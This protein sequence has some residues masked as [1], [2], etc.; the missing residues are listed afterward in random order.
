ML[1]PLKQSE[2]DKYA[3]YAYM[4]SQDLTKSCF[5]TYTDGIKTKEDFIKT[6][7]EAFSTN[8]SEILLF[9]HCGKTIGWI[10][11]YVLTPDKYISFHAFN[12]ESETEKAIDEFIEYI[13]PKYSGFTIYF[14]IPADNLKAASHLIELEF[15]MLEESNVDIL[16]FKDY[17]TRSEAQ[18]CIGVGKNNF[19]DF[20]KL[21][22]IY[23]SE[24]Y[25]NTA[26]IFEHLNE[27]NIFMLYENNEAAGAIYYYI[28]E[29]SM[30]EI[31]GVDFKDNIFNDNTFKILLIKALNDG[32]NRDIKSLTYFTNDKEH[33][34]SKKLGFKFICKYILYTKEI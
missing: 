11:Y 32:K 4:L 13:S 3:D 6:A 26:R 19:S 15:T 10:H 17:T 33:I 8:D 27:W 9:T 21:H 14:G 22:K 20:E 29:N 24:M 31:F 7:N 18:N 34:I 2:F 12:I 30:M 5:P 25:W 16:L 23:D 1:I 28:Y